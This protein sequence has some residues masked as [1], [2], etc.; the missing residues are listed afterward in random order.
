[1]H[2]TSLL[3]TVAVLLARTLIDLDRDIEAERFVIIAEET[4]TQDDIASQV[5]IASVRGLIYARSGRQEEGERLARRAVELID[6]TDFASWRGD[7]R[8]DLAE[9]LRLSGKTAD[10]AASIREAIEILERKGDFAT[11]THA[12]EALD[13]L[14]PA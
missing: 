14:P 4:A 10:A 6:Q 1:M 12:H 8:L 11:A 9:V 3:S 5:G 2:E 7:M 13:A